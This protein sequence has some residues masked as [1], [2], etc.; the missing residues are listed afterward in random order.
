MD[1][2][3]LLEHSMAMA[4]KPDLW[5]QTRILA[6]RNKNISIF[7]ENKKLRSYGRKKQNY[8]KNMKS[9]VRGSAVCNIFKYFVSRTCSKINKTQSSEFFALKLLRCELTR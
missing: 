2:I 8:A 6:V 1:F 5:H 9:Q 7:L 3:V 4:I